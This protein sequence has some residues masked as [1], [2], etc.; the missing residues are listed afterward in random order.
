VLGHDWQFWAAALTAAILVGMSK[1]GL[2]LV[3]SLAVPLMALVMDPIRAAGLLLPIFVVSDVFG[4]YAYRRQFDRRVLAILLPAAMAGIGLGWA[5]ASSVPESAVAG[6]I[7]V[8]GTLFALNLMLRRAPEGPPQPAR[9]APGL[10]WGAVTGFTSF[11]SHSGGPP[12]Q[13]YALPL[14]LPKTV[15]AGTTTVAFAVIT[16]VKLLPYWALGQ[17]TAE[18][19]E[20]SAVLALPAALSVLAGVALVRVLPQRWYFRI[21]VWALLAVSLKLIRDALAAAV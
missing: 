9:V 21:I 1:G 4:L 6:L 5:T 15:F 13:V 14:R 18:S 16:A 19:L 3:G 2:S 12:F 17:L 7:G 20:V 10:F 11:I 8:I